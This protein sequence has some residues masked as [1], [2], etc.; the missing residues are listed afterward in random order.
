[1]GD[2]EHRAAVRPQLRLQP[3]HGPVVQVVR[4]LVQEQDLRAAGEDP[5]QGETGALAP[6]QGAEPALPVERRQPEV[7][8]RDVHAVIGVVAA[9]GLVA[10]EE[11][12]VR[13]QRRRIVAV[14][15]RP[16][17]PA[18]LRL[19]GPQVREGQVDR[20]LDGGGRGQRDGLREIADSA[21]GGHGHLAA[22]RALPPGEDPEQ[23]GF[24]RAVVTDQPGL[25]ARL[26]REGDLVQNGAAGVALGDVT[27]GELW[28]VQDRFPPGR[29]DFRGRIGVNGCTAGRG[30]GGAVLYAVGAGD[31]TGNPCGGRYAM[32]SDMARRYVS[33]H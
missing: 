17:G 16:L 33:P 23:G 7:V 22:V 9:P 19:Q 14:T 18:Q 10:S 4:R 30:D 28:G 29:T 24:A 27:E 6:G 8:Q 31:V 26:E 5:G 13:R 12:G 25:L 21:G 32:T 1:M 11:H 2:R 3:F 20:V 15:E